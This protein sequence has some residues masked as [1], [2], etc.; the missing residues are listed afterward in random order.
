MSD[1]EYDENQEYDYG[2]DVEDDEEMFAHREDNIVDFSFRQLEQVQARDED[3]DMPLGTTVDKGALADIMRRHELMNLDPETKFKLDVQDILNKEVF[4]FTETDKSVI[5]RTIS[6]LPFIKYKNPLLYILGYYIYSDN[7]KKLP[8]SKKRKIDTYINDNSF[9]IAEV[10]KY[11]RY[12]NL[13]L[14]RN[15]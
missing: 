1:D 14:L 11:A 12:W 7:L 5:K 3:L 13:I 8:A 4:Y 10:V 6:Q 2:E 15:R 9:S